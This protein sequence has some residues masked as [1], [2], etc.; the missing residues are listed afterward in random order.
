MAV[1]I[2]PPSQDSKCARMIIGTWKTIDAVIK[3]LGP[4]GRV[5]MPSPKCCLPSTSVPSAM[6]EFLSLVLCFRLYI[7]AGRSG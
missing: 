3:A 4:Y 2:T 7:V 6:W 5:S 1:S